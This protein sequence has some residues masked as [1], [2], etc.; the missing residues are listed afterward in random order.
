M[1]IQM[2][3]MDGIE[4]TLLIREREKGTGRHI[5]ILAMKAHAMKG[6]REKCLASRYGRLRVQAHSSR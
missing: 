3:E 5:P 1:D 6:V 2:P 4:A